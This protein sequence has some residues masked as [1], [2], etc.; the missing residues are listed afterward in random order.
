ME[1][2]RDDASARLR[3]AGGRLSRRLRET[4]AG[5]GLTP[6]QISVLFLIFA[7]T[8]ALAPVVYA[9]TA[10]HESSDIAD[11]EGSV[12]GFLAAGGVSVTAVA[13][14]LSTIGIVVWFQLSAT[15][16]ERY[17]LVAFLGVAAAF[18]ATF[19]FRTLSM[20]AQL[21]SPK[22]P[23]PSPGPDPD[24]MGR[25]GSLMGNERVSATL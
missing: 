15:T 5:T 10:N 21:P 20:Y 13:G 3:A 12:W 19:S 4:R 6:T 24:A 14:E 8:A 17:A 16:P 18:V 9:A 11:L 1:S 23:L 22:T 2:G 25:R 7:G